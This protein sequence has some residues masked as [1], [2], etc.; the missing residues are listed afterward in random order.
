[1]SVEIFLDTNVF[2]SAK[3]SYKSYNMTNFIKYCD[4]NDI[5]LK[6]VDVVKHE[7]EKR[8]KSNISNSFEQIDKD[9]LGVVA[10]SINIDPK[11]SKLNI[12]NQLVNNLKDSFDDFIDENDVEIIDANYEI[13]ELTTQ[14]FEQRSPFTEQKKH[15]FPDAIILLTIKKYI[16]DN[17]NKTITTISNDES[18][19]DFSKSN[20]INNFNFI[21]NALSYLIQNPNIA[22][23]NA[24]NRQ[25][26]SIK[27]Q[28][29]E[30][31]ENMDDFILY[32]YDSID[33]V[34]VDDIS[35]KSVSINDLNII[36]FEESDKMLYLDSNLSI[37]FSCKAYYPDPDTLHYDKED[38]V[39]Y[40]FTRCMSEINF[41]EKI[42]CS[43]EIAFDE[44]FDFDIVE[45]ELHNKEFEFNLDDRYIVNTE[46]E[47]DNIDTF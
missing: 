10:A 28:I 35:V 9:N 37:E 11:I 1:M 36:K 2:E 34:D 19:V 3:F 29:I 20:G 43:L 12:I 46:Y 38:G 39:Y 7:V 31:I 4:D 5:K 47:S 16:N 25:L 13:K 44:D 33:L 21:S 24:F 30:R 6:I 45:L 14:Y 23:K 8:I 27:E 40:S 26:N 41:T 42:T 17:P 32:S 18:F 15:E 22:L